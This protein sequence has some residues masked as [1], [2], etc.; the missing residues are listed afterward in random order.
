MIWPPM[1]HERIPGGPDPRAWA[2]RM[3]EDRSITLSVLDS[4]APA[5]GEIVSSTV[6]RTN[7]GP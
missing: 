1:H 2:G 6:I 7:C 4:G 3:S 5:G